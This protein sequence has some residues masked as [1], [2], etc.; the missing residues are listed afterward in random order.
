M[1]RAAEK[2]RCSRQNLIVFLVYLSMMYG[3]MLKKRD[4]AAQQ[5]RTN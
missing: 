1:G 3:C 4:G 2:M 5:Q